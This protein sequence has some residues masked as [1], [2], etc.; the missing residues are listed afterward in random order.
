MNPRCKCSHDRYLHP[1]DGECIRPCGCQEF[2]LDPRSLVAEDE[3]AATGTE[4]AA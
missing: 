4:G 2:R 1:G 3:T